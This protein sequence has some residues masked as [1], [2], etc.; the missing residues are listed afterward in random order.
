MCNMISCINQACKRN[1]IGRLVACWY[2]ASDNANDAAIEI[3]C[4]CRCSVLS[5]LSVVVKFW[6]SL[7]SQESRPR[8]AAVD[9]QVAQ[10]KIDTLR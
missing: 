3:D 5:L 7:L 2:L 9:V 4:C 8:T 6:L 10:L 1:R